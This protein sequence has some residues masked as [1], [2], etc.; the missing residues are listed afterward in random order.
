MSG[1][2]TKPRDSN[3]T[4]TSTW[5]QCALICDV[6]RSIQ[7]P[8]TSG[9]CSRG[10]MSLEKM[11]H[12]NYHIC[13]NFF[14]R[15]ARDQLVVVACPLMGQTPCRKSVQRTT[16]R[17]ASSSPVESDSPAGDL[18]F[19]IL[20]HRRTKTKANSYFG[21]SVRSLWKKGISICVLRVVCVAHLFTTGACFVNGTKKTKRLAL[22][23]TWS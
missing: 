4:M 18:H 14:F 7:S 23:E 13:P 6:I 16:A 19:K 3:P 22:I 9:F 20:S 1:P 10:H 5:P 8:N 17:T 2:K 12:S 21:K 15:E 11:K